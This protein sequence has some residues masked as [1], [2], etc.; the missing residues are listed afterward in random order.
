M[1]LH[2]NPGE[3]SICDRIYK[4]CFL[5]G[6][7]WK[8]ICCWIS[9]WRLKSDSKWQVSHPDAFCC[10][11]TCTGSVAVQSKYFNKGGSTVTWE[12]LVRLTCLHLGSFRII[13]E[14]CQSSFA[15]LDVIHVILNWNPNDIM[16]FVLKRSLEWRVNHP[17]RWSG[18]SLGLLLAALWNRCEYSTRIPSSVSRK[19]PQE[20]PPY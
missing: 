2:T 10:T 6:T 5:T 19:Q 17:E 14:I 3:V 15:V 12:N 16:T 7:S 13:Q 8:S 9:I 18:A 1:R 11:W 4:H 20:G